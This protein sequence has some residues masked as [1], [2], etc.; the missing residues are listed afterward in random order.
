VDEE[1]GGA[2]KA[3]RDALKL[4]AVV[5]KHSDSKSAQQRLVCLDRP[6]APPPSAEALCEH[7]FMLIQDVGLTF[8][9]PDFFFRKKNYVN[10]AR[11]SSTRVWA[12]GGGCVGNIDRPFLGTLERPRISEAGRVFLADLLNQLRDSQIRELFEASRVTLRAE[13]LTGEPHT[14]PSVEDWVS[15]F[16]RKRQEVDARRC[17][18]DQPVKDRN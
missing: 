7:P 8:G 9:K 11:W 13:G 15:V 4:L 2:P 14:G 18:P 3:H 16:K 6:S 10:L 1:A 17:P 12:E 5:I